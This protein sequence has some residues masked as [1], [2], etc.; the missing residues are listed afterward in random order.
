LQEILVGR[1]IGRLKKQKREVR[2]AKQGSDRPG[3]AAAPAASPGQASP[4]INWIAP[5]CAKS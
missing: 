4:T 1:N 5:L 3:V 2:H